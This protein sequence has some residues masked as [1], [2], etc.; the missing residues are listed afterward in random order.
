MYQP[1]RPQPEIDIDQILER[2]KDFFRR[3]TGK[4]GFGGSGA[5]VFAVLG[6]LV[7]IWLATGFYQVRP[8]SWPQCASSA[9]TP[10]TCRG[11]DFTGSGLRPSVPAT[12]ETVT[13]TRRMELGFRSLEGGQITDVPFE[14]LMITG[15]L[16]I[17]DVQLVVQYRTKDL[18]LLPFPGGRPR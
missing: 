1:P 18:A 5:L 7:V 13:E 16:N 15:D 14:A 12:I 17:A 8:A 9:P 10:A 3:F 11:Q 2:V 4:F 6:I